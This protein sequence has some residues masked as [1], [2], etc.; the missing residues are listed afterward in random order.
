MSWRVREGEK[1]NEGSDLL[2]SAML[3][4]ALFS[5]L[6]IRPILPESELR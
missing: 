1:P 4:G 6:M 3:I 2:A 5:D